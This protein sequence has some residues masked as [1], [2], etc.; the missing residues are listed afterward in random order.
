MVGL[1]GLDGLDPRHDSA[2][3]GFLL[4]ER[5]WGHGYATQAAAVVVWFGF[6]VLKLNR[7]YARHLA[8][9]AASARVLAKV[10]MQREGVLREFARKPKGFEDVVVAAIPRREW[11]ACGKR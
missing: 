2:E 8:S 5:Y 3:L 9:N 11:A 6:R 1:I 4:N 7:I 10:G